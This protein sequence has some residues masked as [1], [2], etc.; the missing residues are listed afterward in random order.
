MRRFSLVVSILGGTLLTAP[1]LAQQPVP[2]APQAQMPLRCGTVLAANP[3]GTGI[4]NPDCDYNQ[5]NPSSIYA[6]GAILRIPVVVHVI[7]STSGQGFLSAA[8]VQ[9][10]I[11]V[12]NEDFGAQAGTAGANGVDTKIEFFLATTDPNGQPTTGI[13]YITNN[14]WFQ[15]SGNYWS[16]TAWDTSRYLN[17]YTNQASGALGYVPDLPQGGSVLGTTADRVVVYYPSFGRPGTLTPYHLGRTTTHEVGHYLGLFHTF[18]GGC[19]G[20][21]CYTSGDRICDTNA[22]SGARF[23][24]PTT[25]TS[26]G[27][28]DPVRNYMDY[29]DDACMQGFT[30]EQARRMRCTITS[31]RPALAQ[32]AGPL[33]S[34]TVRN[35]AGN[36]NGNFSATPPLLGGTSTL[37]AITLG[38]GYSAAAAY[39]FLGSA[40]T[41]FAGYTVLVDVTSPQLL[42]LPF[43]ASAIAVQ[44]QFNVPNSQTLAGLPIS[45]QALFFGSTV[46]FTNAVDLVLGN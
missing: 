24:C 44:W 25:S 37:S 17:I 29:T 13:D 32:P 4:D 5:T 40:N 22:E 9:S 28:L 7:Q 36:L 41:P 8:R 16:T 30:Q 38:T 10:Q 19:G 43:T 18:Q 2:Q 26:C 23:G 3:A 6:P 46:A 35:G 33:A 39:G 21:N 12:L 14:T 15:D 42:V 34:A 1:L 45:T 20:S 27:N 31:Y 11:T